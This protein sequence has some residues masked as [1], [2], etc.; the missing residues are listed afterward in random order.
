MKFNF[1]SEL[2]KDKGVLLFLCDKN[3]PFQRYLEGL[4]KKNTNYIKRAMKVVDFNY[5]ENNKLELILPKGSNSDRIII[6]GFDKNSFSSDL[7]LGKLGSSITTILNNKKI[8][9]AS[10]VLN[11][12]TFNA[13][14][15][16]LL[17]Y[18][19]SLNTYRFNKYFSDQKK[20][21]KKVQ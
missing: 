4:D 11:H 9:E 18:G 12:K 15:V 7:Y 16:A 2:S 20:T 21:R 10:L 1:N 14:E 17:M 5:K 13:S 19:I 6:L 8:K 3:E